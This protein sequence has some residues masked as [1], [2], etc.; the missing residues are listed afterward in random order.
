[1]LANDSW[2]RPA[3]LGH[4]I[5]TTR[6]PTDVDTTIIMRSTDVCQ[7][8]LTLRRGTTDVENPATRPAQGSSRRRPEGRATTFAAMRRMVVLGMAA[9]VFSCL[10]VLSFGYAQHSPRPHGVRIDVVA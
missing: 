7:R 4:V 8:A 1:M 2:P 10:L 9:G 5:A 6:W 3:A